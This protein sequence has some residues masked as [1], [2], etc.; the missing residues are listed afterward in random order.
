[1]GLER[2]ATVTESI[3]IGIRVVWIGFTCID[4]AVPGGRFHCVRQ[5]HR[6]AVVHM[7]TNKPGCSRG[8]LNRSDSKAAKALYA[9]RVQPAALRL[10]ARMRVCS[11]I[12]ALDDTSEMRCRGH[13]DVKVVV[14][15]GVV[16]W[17]KNNIP[18]PIVEVSPGRIVQ[19]LRASAH[20]IAGVMF[21]FILED[22]ARTGGQVIS[23]DIDGIAEGVL[24]QRVGSRNCAT[25]VSS[26]MSNC[27]D[28]MICGIEGGSGQ[29]CR[30]LA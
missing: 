9:R 14:V 13:V 19:K 15:C 4:H 18:H 20:R 7:N 12:A 6:I 22:I 17:C 8:Y 30:P 5:P 1:M 27:T 26:D 24:R 28:A 29:S 10:F 23:V 16:V 25:V 21:P 2:H 11:T 3:C